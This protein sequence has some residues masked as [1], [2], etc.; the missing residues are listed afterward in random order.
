MAGFKDKTWINNSAP[1]LED[2]DL[3][4]FKNEFN[5]T[6]VSSGQTP[7]N[8]DLLQTSKAM[9]IY[10]AGSDYYTDSGTPNNYVLTASNAFEAPIAYFPGMRVRFRPANNN[11]AAST[12]NVNS[13][14]VKNIKIVT[15]EDV[16]T[17]YITTDQIYEFIYDGTNFVWA[18]DFRPSRKIDSL[19]IPIHTISFTGIETNLFFV[20]NN[21]NSLIRNFN[22]QLCKPGRVYLSFWI[23]GSA[24]STTEFILR[25]R[26][27]SGTGGTILFERNFGVLGNQPG[28]FINYNIDLSTG[29]SIDLDLSTTDL[30]TINSSINPWSLTGIQSVDPAGSYQIRNVEFLYGFF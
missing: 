1:Q 11:T 3:N 5:N 8:A 14:G 2:A 30:M 22:K 9:A 16:Q 29:N 26:Q 15:D 7:S 24:N 27:G 23:E 17:D 18:K 20:E 6:F 25:I 21:T 28:E 19:S 12:I 13:L 10:T 4:G